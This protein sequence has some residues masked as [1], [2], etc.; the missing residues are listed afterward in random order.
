[1]RTPLIQGARSSVQRARAA[2]KE[3]ATPEQKLI[4]DLSGQIP[5]GKVLAAI[6]NMI[7][8]PVQFRRTIY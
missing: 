8:A 7:A 6:V 5:I 4:K 3:K 2:A 1:M